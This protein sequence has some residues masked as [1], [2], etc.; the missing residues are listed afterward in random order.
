MR[1][2]SI[3]RLCSLRRVQKSC[4]L[5]SL[6][7]TFCEPPSRHFLC[8]THFPFMRDFGKEGLRD[9]LCWLLGWARFSGP[10][11]L[12]WR[13]IHLEG[14]QALLKELSGTFSSS[15]KGAANL[16]LADDSFNPGGE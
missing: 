15:A 12:K 11:L 7:V 2:F 6:R 3:S 14:W 13:G 4:L 1:S 5:C 8:Q 9:C 16:E 10:S